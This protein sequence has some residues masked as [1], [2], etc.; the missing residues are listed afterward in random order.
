MLQSA[1]IRQQH[2]SRLLIAPFRRL[3]PAYSQQH[4]AVCTQAGSWAAEWSIRLLYDP[5]GQHTA[6]DVCRFATAILPLFTRHSTAIREQSLDIWRRHYV[7]LWLANGGRLTV[8]FR[9]FVLNGSRLQAVWQQ[10]GSS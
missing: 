1:S 6:T 10:K 9:R 7:P 3:L 2:Y 8:L 4:L 5:F